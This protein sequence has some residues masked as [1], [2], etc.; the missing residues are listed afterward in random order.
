MH[1]T[2]SW[3]WEP[4]QP[5][6]SV[7]CCGVIG[8]H[9]C[10]YCTIA[11]AVDCPCENAVYSIPLTENGREGS[12]VTLVVFGDFFFFCI[13]ASTSTPGLSPHVEADTNLLNYVKMENY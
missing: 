11:S 10:H 7:Q 2:S 8:S 6:G 12:L 4:A 9:V 13:F 3:D 5:T 1:A